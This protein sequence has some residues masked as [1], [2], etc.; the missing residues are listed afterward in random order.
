[1]SPRP[2]ANRYRQPD[3]SPI[4]WE[5][6]PVLARSG[7]HMNSGNER[8]VARLRGTIAALHAGAADLDAVLASLHSALDLVENDGSGVRELVRLAEADIEEIRFTRL[9]G[10]Q[11]PAVTRRLDE[12]AA[13]LEAARA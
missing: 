8:V 1:M 3:C 2:D 9:L 12:L 5:K 7:E 6:F 11:R 13:A 4:R 10:E